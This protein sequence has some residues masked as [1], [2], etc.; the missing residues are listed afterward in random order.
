MGRNLGG[1][2]RLLAGV[3]AI[4]GGGQARA[5]AKVGRKD[6]W[7]GDSAS[8][9]ACGGRRGAIVC[10][11]VV[12]LVAQAQGQAEGIAKLSKRLDLCWQSACARAARLAGRRHKRRR[13]AADA[14]EVARQRQ[15]QGHQ[16]RRG[17]QRAL[18]DALHGLRVVADHARVGGQGHLTGG[19]GEQI[20]AHHQGDAAA[21]LAHAWPAAAALG[22]VHQILV[23]LCGGVEQLHGGGGVNHALHAVG[24]GAGGHQHQ[25]GPQPHALGP[26]QARASHADHSGAAVGA[27]AHDLLNLLEIGA[28]RGRK[29]KLFHGRCPLQAGWY[30]WGA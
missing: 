1:G 10:G 21:P 17:H 8:P 13:R 9:Q 5:V 22:L 28:E 12:E 19:K 30:R 16:G 27:L 11:E 15:I 2:P 25:R 20:V 14:F 23:G 24:A 3:A 6:Q 4:D 29:R 26:Q 18:G 7:R